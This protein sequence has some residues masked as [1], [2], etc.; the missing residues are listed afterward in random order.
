M[1]KL[2]FLFII[3]AL[4]LGAKP[5]EE[6]KTKKTIFFEGKFD[7]TGVIVEKVYD[8]DNIKLEDGKLISVAD[9][10][11]PEGL[12]VSTRNFLR[13][14]LENKKVKVKFISDGIAKFIKTPSYIILGNDKVI[15]VELVRQGYTVPV[16]NP[17]AEFQ[18]KFLEAQ[19]QA[20]DAKLGIWAEE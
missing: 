14:N 13:E 7:Y 6:D 16:L 5:V 20:Q 17:N 12:R 11:M 18:E 19:N 1:K 8:I 2:I 10:Q 3:S 15:N 4:C 9:V